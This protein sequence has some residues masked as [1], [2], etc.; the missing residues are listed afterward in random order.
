M[1]ADTARL[2]RALAR[3]EESAW[4]EFH[5]LYYEFLLARVMARGV[6]ES[7]ASEV[8]QRVYLRV[9]K[10]PKA[11]ERRADFEAW[12]SCLARCE[13]IDTGRSVRRRSW[14]R[15][16]FEQWSAVR[17]EAVVETPA[18][19]GRL[20]EA[21]G[22]LDGNERA[23]LTRHYYGGWSQEELAREHGISVKAIESRLA[24]L[25]SRLRTLM[26]ES[27]ETC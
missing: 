5:A 25:R 17:H 18:G 14:L 2:T 1:D 27:P 11:F 23:L 21:L 10:N 22:S 19:D 7:E 20:S 6:V 4:Q 13:A 24:R 3:C 8:V 15:E 9:L 12:L 26:E 16:K